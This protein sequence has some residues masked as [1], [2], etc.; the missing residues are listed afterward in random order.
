MSYAGAYARRVGTAREG[1]SPSLLVGCKNAS[2]VRTQNTFALFSS[3]VCWDSNRCRMSHGLPVLARAMSPGCCENSG[4]CQC[5]RKGR[6]YSLCTLTGGQ[7]SFPFM[8]AKISA[9]DSWDKSCGRY[10]YLLM[11]LRSICESVREARVQGPLFFT[12][13]PFSGE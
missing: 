3:S 12:G 9:E 6:I 7:R 4:L 2:A 11:T 10:V 13:F 5:V 8:E 1:S